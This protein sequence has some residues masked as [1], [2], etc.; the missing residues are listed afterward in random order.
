MGEAAKDTFIN[1]FC[2][3]FLFGMD[4]SFSGLFTL[5]FATDS[6]GDFTLFFNPSC[7]YVGLSIPFALNSGC[8]RFDI[9][10][11]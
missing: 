6:H 1:F 5:G 11:L 4:N 10:G 9:T 2:L 7:K 3:K 8:L